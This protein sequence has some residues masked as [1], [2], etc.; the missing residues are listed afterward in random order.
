MLNKIIREIDGMIKRDPAA[1]SR[2]E[3]AL[4]YPAFHAIL[5]YR[6]T[7]WMWKRGW[8]LAPRF[9]S[10][11]ARFITGIEIHP[12]ATIGEG[13]FIDHGMGV[14]IGET[15]EIGN[16]VTL[17]HDVTL[18]G[19]SPSEDSDQQR[20]T[21]RHPTLNDNVIV[22][23]GAQILGPITVGACA[24][25]GANAVVIKDVPERAT[26][27]GIPARVIARAK[28]AD[29][30]FAPYGTPLGEL[31]DPVARAMD[32]LMEHVSTLNARIKD[33]ESRLD[34]ATKTSGSLPYKPAIDKAE[35][36]KQKQ[37]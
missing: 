27:V 25:V 22:G 10:Q 7:N 32:G 33:L 9:L 20:C 8:R 30:E 4:C 13:F 2:I 16:N 35:G 36:K 6:G 12:G 26:V 19:V 5:M 24:R 18:G 29:G 28:S 3:I 11:T 31:P 14:V 1:R 37:A 17:Y 21:K 34:E 15:A 23:S